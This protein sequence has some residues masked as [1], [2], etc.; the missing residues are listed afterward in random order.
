MSGGY[1]AQALSFLIRTAFDLYLLAVVLRFLLQ[2]VQADFYNPISQF[3]IKVTNPALKYIRRV[4]PG[5]KG[6]DWSSMVLMLV[7]KALEISILSF[8]NYATMP[9]I[10]GLIVLS[11][12]QL[13]HLIIYIFIIAIFIQVILSW[14]NPGAY[15]PATVLLYR[16]TDPLMRP[17]RKLIQ[18]IGGLDLS[19]IIVFVFLQLIIILFVNPLM[20][21]GQSL[22]G[23]RYV[24]AI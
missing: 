2:V 8:I 18:P 6:Q 12:A 9:A 23:I 19:P 22:S 16:L 3:L 7:I 5:Y 17:A 4:V 1:L 15:N 21:F 20:H 24:I 13:L 14:V 10:H 11:L